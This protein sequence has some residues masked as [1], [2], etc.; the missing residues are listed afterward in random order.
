MPV[1]VQCLAP[2]RYLLSCKRDAFKSKKFYYTMTSKKGSLSINVK[3]FLDPFETLARPLRY[4][5]SLVKICINDGNDYLQIK[6]FKWSQ[7]LHM[8]SFQS[9][10]DFLILMFSKLILSLFAKMQNSCSRY[11]HLAKVLSVKFLSLSCSHSYKMC[12][13]KKNT[14]SSSAVQY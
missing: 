13:S 3:C 6:R 12:E 2:R 4:F 9:S 7:I 1:L 14:K 8:E 5:C 10:T 11:G